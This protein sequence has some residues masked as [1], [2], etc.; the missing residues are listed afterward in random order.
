LAAMKRKGHHF[1]GLTR[2]RISSKLQKWLE[3]KGLRLL[4]NGKME[5]IVNTYEKK[6]KHHKRQKLVVL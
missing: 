4:D 3:G 1:P 5:P 6:A 2:D